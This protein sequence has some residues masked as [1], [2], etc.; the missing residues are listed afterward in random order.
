M[1]NANI[2]IVKLTTKEIL[3]TMFDISTPFFLAS[4]MYRQSVRKYLSGREVD[5]ANFFDKIQYLKRQGYVKSFTENKEKFIEITPK[6]LMQFNNLLLEDL[7]ITRPPKWDGKWRIVIF[8]I[9]ETKKHN[10]DLFRNN[11]QNL[12]FVQ[13]QKSVYVY[14]FECTNE[15]TLICEHLSIKKYITILI[16][17]II[18]GEE[19]IIDIFI[20]N[21]ILLKSDL[22][23]V[24]K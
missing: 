16:A 2:E 18:Q 6:G 7:I 9:P 20:N 5:R 17:E 3:L 23:R 19:K 21:N 10:R 13:V 24:L 12:Y 8:D 11:L 15:I 22:K 4:R 1:K 14:P